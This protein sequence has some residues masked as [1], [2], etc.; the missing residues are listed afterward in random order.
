MKLYNKTYKDRNEGLNEMTA[1]HSC[2]RKEVLF[3][4]NA[5]FLFFNFKATTH[6][7]HLLLPLTHKPTQ[8]QNQKSAIF[9]RF[10]FR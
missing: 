9:Q 7:T 4:A 3:F 5:L 6:C 8:W 2:R 10:I 1:E